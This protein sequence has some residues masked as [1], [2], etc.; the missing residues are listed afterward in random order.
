VRGDA[1]WGI[2]G[3]WLRVVRVPLGNLAAWGDFEVEQ[4]AAPGRG[5]PPPDPV[6]MPVVPGHPGH[7]LG[8]DPPAGQ[9]QGS[10]F[11]VTCGGAGVYRPGKPGGLSARADHPRLGTARRHEDKIHL[12]VA[13]QGV[14]LVL[15]Y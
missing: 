5:L 11:K 8:Q 7:K 15:A 10:P 6:P 14:G 1:W 4:P 9:A 3:G 2:G 13:A 12:V